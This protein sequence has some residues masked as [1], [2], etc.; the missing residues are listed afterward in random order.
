MC[1]Q[2]SYYVTK[3]IKTRSKLTKTLFKFIDKK[4]AQ[5]RYILILFCFYS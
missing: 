2:V 5:G 3:L 4:L 1:N